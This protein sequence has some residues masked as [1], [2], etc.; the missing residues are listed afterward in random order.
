M[1]LNFKHRSIIIK[2]VNNSYYKDYYEVLSDNRMRANK[3]LKTLIVTL[4]FQY[5]PD[6][7]KDDP[8]TCN[9]M[10]ALNEAYA[11]LSDP[12]KRSDM[13]CS[14][15]VWNFGL[16]TISANPFPGRYFQGLRYRA[17]IPGIFKI[18][19]LP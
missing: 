6:R 11:I 18:I 7:N 9:K 13:I 14:R 16:P 8:A 12:V 19:W 2:L 5:H 4:A 1:V 17:D 15:K 3:R 10:K